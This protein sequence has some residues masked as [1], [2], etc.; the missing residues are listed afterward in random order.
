VDEDN[1]GEID[2]QEFLQ[3]IAHHRTLNAK[4]TREQDTVDAFVAL[5]GNV[6]ILELL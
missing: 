1:S 4:D 2:F 5:G 6:S 3:V